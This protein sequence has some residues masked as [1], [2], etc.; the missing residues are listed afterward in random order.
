MNAKIMNKQI[1]NKIMN[2][3]NGHCRSHK[4]TFILEFHF[5]L[6]TVYTYIYIFKSDP[7]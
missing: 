1:C 5:F 3:L 2:A 4:I 6:Y 7:I